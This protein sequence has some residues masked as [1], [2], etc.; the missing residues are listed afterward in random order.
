MLKKKSKVGLYA[1][2]VVVLILLTAAGLSYYYLLSPFSSVKETVYLYVDN[3]DTADSVY[4]KLTPISSRHAMTGFTTLARHT[5]YEQ[6]VRTGR[7]A[8]EPSQRVYEVLR[9][10]K[11][12]RQQPLML[13]LP[14]ARTT[15]LMAGR[16]GQRLMADSTALAQ[17][18]TDSAV[19]AGLGFDTTT[20]IALFIPDSYEVYWDI[21][22]EQLLK[23][24]KKE[25]DAFWNDTRRAQA[26]AIGLT[27]VEV[28]T[29]ASIVD[30]ET[31]NN[32]EKPTVAGMYMNRLHKRMPLQA[33]PTVKFALGDFSLRR[34][35]R[36]MLTVDSPYNTYR[37]LG[38]P[39]GPIRVASVAGI[40][41]V[42]HHPTH[43][44]LYM[45]ANPD[46]SGTHI[47]AQTYREHLKNAQ[48]YSQALNERGIK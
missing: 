26:E 39:P 21:S 42:L 46:F 41:A 30:E 34:I 19:C 4:A 17:L 8:I 47:F 32:A 44:Y 14:V 16:L 13:T 1:T 3:D 28:Q 22:P 6:K 24:M 11:N 36:K 12:G 37:N 15:R 10:V 35:Y 5:G 2:I 18:L 48:R 38:L 33:D 43:P 29:L 20:V 31:A 40:E 9:Q 23:R 25:R 27:P 7:Y 45:C